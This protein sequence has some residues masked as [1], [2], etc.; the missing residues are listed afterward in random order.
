MS[1]GLLRLDSSESGR[2]FLFNNG[3]CV[4]TG[5][6][7]WTAMPGEK[8][9]DGPGCFGVFLWKM[10]GPLSFGGALRMPVF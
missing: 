5:D 8:S 1:D 3:D 2:S 6:D 10:L 7:E 4:R 9:I